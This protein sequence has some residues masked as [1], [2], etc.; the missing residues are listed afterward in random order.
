MPAR[1]VVVTGMHRSGTSLVASV[2]QRAGAHMGERLLEADRR[3]PRGFFE[4]VDFYGFHQQAF[5]DRGR[6]PYVGSDFRFEA[7]PAEIEQAQR[8][9]AAREHQALW[10]FKDP[11]ACLFLEFWR[12][13]IPHA[14]FLLLYRH[15]L[16]VLASL[17]RRGE[18]HTVGLSE[19]IEAWYAYN[20]AIRR[21]AAEHADASLVCHAYAAAETPRLLIE[22]LNAKCNLG[23][24]CDGEAL[25]ALYHRE[26]LRRL[27]LTPTVEEIFG[28]LY[29]E[30]RDLYRTLEA[31]ADLPCGPEP[32]EHHGTSPDLVALAETLA[33]LPAPHPPSR[34]RGLLLL[35][36]AGLDPELVEALYTQHGAYVRDLEGTR[37]HLRSALAWTKQLEAEL[38]AKHAGITHLEQALVQREHALAARDE[39]IAQRDRALTARHEEIARLEAALA[40]RNALIERQAGVMDEQRG[41]IGQL[42]ADVARQSG[43]IAG[44]EARL[45]RNRYRRFVGRLRHAVR[46]LL[47]WRRGPGPRAAV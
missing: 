14:C 46:G 25:A 9:V 4:D 39:E 12:A 47:T 19:G 26:D 33:R 44:L 22:Q 38:A 13:R 11:R 28:R 40:G 21:F 37:E 18:P 7:T 16:E 10:G 35:T 3:N 30:C 43:V 2:L 15:P 17:V 1:V 29:P 5:A 23:L 36:L 24:S 42:E 27:P 6:T 20:L 45:L 8:L 34:R 41:R 32:G 31:A